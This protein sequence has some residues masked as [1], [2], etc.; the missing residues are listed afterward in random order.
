[1]K[2]GLRIVLVLMLIVSL[3]AVV[4]CSNQSPAA[5]EA[6]VLKVGSDIAYAP[7]EYYDKDQKATGFDIELLTAIAEDLGYT[8]DFESAP[9]DGLI[10]SVQQGKYDCI[11]SAMTIK[12]DRAKSVLFSD[13]YFKAVQY[14]AFNKGENFEKIA[15]LA[16][17]KIGVQLNTT[18]Q[19]AVE[20]AGMNPEKFKFLPDALNALL[21]GGVDVVVADNQPVLVFIENN[22]NANIECVV[23]DT[24]DEFYG[25]AMKLG[26]TELAEGIN[27]TL[28]K[29]K[30]NGKYAEIYSKWFKG[31]VPTF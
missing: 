26:N 2:K 18:G 16:G 14:I 1:M 23:A 3:V 30:E 4:G 19:Y 21:I 17:Q 5:D 11:I 13:P 22:P 29:F 15:D 7:F 9:F 6:K 25:I 10:T 8:V 27:T 28:A 24:E 31:E 20:D 12:E